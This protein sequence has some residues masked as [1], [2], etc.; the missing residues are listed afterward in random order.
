MQKILSQKFN[1]RDAETP[2][3]FEREKI[4]IQ[5]SK[6]RNFFSLIS[7]R[8]CVSA[9]L[10]TFAACH[11]KPTDLRTLAP[12]ET[13][14]YM[15]VNDLAKTLNSLTESKSFQELATDKPDFSAFENV[16]AAVVVT[17]FETSEQKLTSE[18]SVLNFKPLFAVIADTHA[19]KPTAVS[20]AENQIGKFAKD[21]YGDEVKLEKSEKA[22]AKFFVW[23]SSDGRKLFSAV[24][25]SVIYVGNDESILDKCL[26]VGRGAAESL[27]KNENVARARENA[28]SENLLAFGYAAPEAVAQI[29][30]VAGVSAAIETTEEDAGRSFIAQVLPQILRNTTGEIVWTAN[31]S[32]RGIED[33]I[34][35]SLNNETASV[36]KETLISNSETETN[37]AEFLPTEIFSATRYN[38]KNPL[39]AWRSLLLVTAKNTD[40]LSGKFLV[41]LSDG[42]LE[43]YGVANAETFL[44]QIESEILT[45]Q[46]DADGEK[47]VVIVTVKNAEELKKSISNEINFKVSSKKTENA[48]VWHSEDKQIAAAFVE[49]KLILG[50][51]EMVLKCLQAKQTGQNFTKNQLFQNLKESKSVA[52]TFAKDKNSAEKIVEVLG[53]AQEN[54]NTIS[55]YT[56]E[57]RFGENGIERKTVSA[58]GLL[59]T[60]LEQLEE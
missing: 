50:D 39:I 35:V 32:E 19:W 57:T 52:F 24:S 23:T 11:T 36:F 26:A 34:F 25:G 8:L 58:F 4:K 21:N 18:D 5:I 31:R 37:S 12:A 54:K 46:F 30:N 59:G 43:P 53:N 48:S 13:F 14:V 56:T 17:G 28:K 51:G 27:V 6:W 47:S 40:A 7:L 2:R 20:I 29:A 41:H 45:A 9:V 22:D 3:F 15:E 1:R 55:V 44:S 60:I 16:Q 33:T 42:L 38:L 49:N 10:I